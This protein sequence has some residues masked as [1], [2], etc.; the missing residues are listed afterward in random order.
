MADKGP[1]LNPP[2]V[3]EMLYGTL[4]WAGVYESKRYPGK[5]EIKL[6]GWWENATKGKDRDQMP[7]GTRGAVWLPFKV[8]EPLAVAGL[9]VQDTND[10]NR[11]T[12]LKGQRFYVSRE[13]IPT[14]K[15]RVHNWFA[16]GIDAQG[17]TVRLERR[18]VPRIP[19][20]KAELEAAGSTG[21]SPAPEPAAAA[22]TPQNPAPVAQP[23]PGAT[24]P[25]P[26]EPKAAPSKNGDKA[27]ELLQE[28][29]AIYGASLG[30]AAYRLMCIYE[31]PIEHIPD[32][33][34]QAG[35]ATVLRYLE[36]RGYTPTQ[37][38]TQTM[39]RR[40]LDSS[41][42][43]AKRPDQ[44]G[45]DDDPKVAAVTTAEKAWV[46]RPEGFSDEEADDDLPF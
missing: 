24:N 35:A 6:D 10:R 36:S 41:A 15:G 40:A 31:C 28:A 8:T 45:R 18:P 39:I 21:P 20:T 33:T 9:I 37:A 26:A 7:V 23:A 34:L 5:M 4:E 42:E 25:A 22:P 12:V 16:A 27:L 29:D 1:R 13:E 19:A 32:R 2:P 44:K 11:F 43:R 17:H 46:D 30:I 14:D 38:G 3:G